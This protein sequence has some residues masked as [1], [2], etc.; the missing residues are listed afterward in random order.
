MT[1]TLERQAARSVHHDLRVDRED[2]RFWNSAPDVVEIEFVVRNTATTET[3]NVFYVP[4]IDSVNDGTGLVF[5]PEGSA[6]VVVPEP[7]DADLIR[8]GLG[9]LGI[10]GRRR[11]RTPSRFL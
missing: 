6:Y 3:L 8:V 1:L 7:G 4:A 9:A 2:I 5:F 11:R 10:L